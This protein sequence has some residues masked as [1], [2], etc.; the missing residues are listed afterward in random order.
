MPEHTMIGYVRFSENSIVPVKATPGS[1]AV[2]L[3]SAENVMI[4]AKGRSLVSTDIGVVL[5][6]NTCGT[7]MSRSGLALN[8]DISVFAGLIDNDYRGPIKII[9]FNDGPGDFEIRQ[10]MRIAQL[11]IQRVVNAFLCE[12]REMTPTQRGGGG[13]G[14]TGS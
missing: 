11:L 5:P 6:E 14:S 1:S 2:D 13:F 12:V 4:P 8:Q 7:I 3:F 10:G 9:V